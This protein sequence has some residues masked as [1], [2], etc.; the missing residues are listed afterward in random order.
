MEQ[1]IAIR[2]LFAGIAWEG[3]GAA[4]LEAL[5]TTGLEYDSRRVT[6]GVLFFAFQGS[7]EDGR[8]YAAD[9]LARGAVA[10]VGETAAP[11]GYAGPWIR[12]P[13]LRQA[14]AL[15]SRRFYGALDERL[16]LTG[17]TGTNGKTTTTYLVDAIWRQAGYRS[18]LIGTIQYR[19]GDEILP[20]VNTTPESLDLHR[21]M[22]RLAAA[23]G[24]HLTLEVS[25][26][27][28]ELRRVSGLRF[29][30]AAFTNLTRDHLDFH[31]TMERYFAAKRRLFEG[32]DAPPPRNVVL[33]ADDAWSRRIPAPP[34]AQVWWYGLTE[35]AQV[36][37]V[38][39]RSHLGG[40]DLSIVYDGRRVPVRSPLAG[41]VNVYNLLAAFCCGLAG[42]VPGDVAAAG[43]AACAAVPGRLERVDEGQPFG[44]F[45][46]YAH[47]DDAL[48][49]VVAALRE[50]TRGR[51]ITLFGCGGDRY[52][53]KRPLM[54]QAAGEASDFV[55]LTSDNPRSEDPLAIINDAL[56]GLRR[57]DVPHAVEPD[58]AA[59]IRRAISEAAS[60]DVVLLAG[61]GHETYQ[62]AGGRMIP[63]DDREVARAVLRSFGYRKERP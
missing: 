41:R 62:A 13:H 42:G 37:A 2:D 1:S 11:S 9:A 60:G 53:D 24:S 44:V 25:S 33:N 43:L 14:L 52:R 30:T 56:V 55:V 18:G 57:T 6:P 20:A 63:F 12:V 46:D 7:R 23:G 16:H 40:L 31:I 28:L 35:A 38:D 61:K 51:V 47:T 27:A 22:A 17:V 49:N 15:A 29:Q 19:I 54:G 36:R 32:A 59:A 3:K 34:G 58:R 45:V 4:P 21:L 50:I 10:A 8:Q 5:V 26:H 48:R 39:I